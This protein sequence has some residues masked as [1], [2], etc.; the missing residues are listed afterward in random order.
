MCDLACRWWFDSVS[1]F[2]YSFRDNANYYGE[3][4][5]YRDV[6]KRATSE[7]AHITECFEL[8][9]PEYESKCFDDIKNDDDDESNESM[10]LI[11]T[12]L[13]VSCCVFI[14]V[15]LSLL[16]QAFGWFASGK[17]ALA[18]QEV[19]PRHRGNSEL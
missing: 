10:R 15:L 6:N 13:V 14:A 8:T 17:S 11:V 1:D 5:N 19:T 4:I 16:S 12:V 9:L 18:R 3:G 2:D 7:S